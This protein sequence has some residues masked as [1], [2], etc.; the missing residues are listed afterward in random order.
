MTRRNLG[1]SDKGKGIADDA[2]EEEAES[3]LDPAAEAQF[4]EEIRLATALSLGQQV[5]MTRG[6]GET[7]GVAKD[8]TENP[9]AIA[10][11]PLSQV[12]D[13]ALGSQTNASRDGVETSEAHGVAPNSDLPLPPPEPTPS[14]DEDEAQTVREGEIPL[15]QLQAF[16]S[17]WKCHHHSCCPTMMQ[18]PL[19]PGWL[20]EQYGVHQLLLN[21]L[22]SLTHLS[23]LMCKKGNKSIMTQVLLVREVLRRLM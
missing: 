21:R 18:Q 6:P 23:K 19:Q 17:I 22:R 11:I 3:E 1:R 15:L 2:Q 4:Q 8:S 16:P 20:I 12:A 13:S 10:A 7:S 5:E 9:I 14:T